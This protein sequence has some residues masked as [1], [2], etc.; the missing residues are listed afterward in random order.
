[1]R[2]LD[3]HI[4]GMIIGCIIGNVLVYGASAIYTEF[5][6]PK[7]EYEYNRR[8]NII[9]V[10]DDIDNDKIIT[11]V[12]KNTGVEYIVIENKSGVSVSPIFN[13]DGSLYTE[14]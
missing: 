9:S 13:S 1:M 14:H 8:Y 7:P 10:Q 6:K 11:L 5:K 3:Q 2:D 4:I 12:D